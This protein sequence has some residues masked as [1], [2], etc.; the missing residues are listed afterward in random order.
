MWHFPIIVLTNSPNHAFVL[1]LNEDLSNLFGPACKRAQLERQ[2]FQVQACRPWTPICTILPL[3][4]QWNRLLRKQ[5]S[6]RRHSPK[7]RRLPR[8]PPVYFH[9]RTMELN[10]PKMRHNAIA[11]AFPSVRACSRLIF[12]RVGCEYFSA[13][14]ACGLL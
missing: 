10:S 5:P 13:V 9:L 11:C 2:P 14:C 3:P 4:S 7:R 1:H 8:C 12:F 6:T